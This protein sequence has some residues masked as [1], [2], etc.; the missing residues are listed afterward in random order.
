VFY[1]HVVDCFSK[2]LNFKPEQNTC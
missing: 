1:K 2:L